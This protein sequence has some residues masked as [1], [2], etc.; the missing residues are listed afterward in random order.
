MVRIKNE[1]VMMMIGSV[2]MFNNIVDPY[3]DRDVG[4]ESKILH[5]VCVDK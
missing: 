2:Q 4:S 1:V 5:C 3:D